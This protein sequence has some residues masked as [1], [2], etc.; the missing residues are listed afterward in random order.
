MNHEAHPPHPSPHAT[1]GVASAALPSIS[2]NGITVDNF[3]LA[4]SVLPMLSSLHHDNLTTECRELSALPQAQCPEAVFG[5]QF[6]LSWGSRGGSRGVTFSGS[7]ALRCWA[8]GMRSGYVPLKSKSGLQRDL[9][10]ASP[11]GQAAKPADYDWTF[12]SPYTCSFS[13][14]QSLAFTPLPET[15][16]DYNLLSSTD[17]RILFYREAVLYEDDLH[18]EG[19]SSLDVKVRAMPTCVFL[20][21]R[22][23]VRVD[24]VVVRNRSECGHA[25]ARAVNICMHTRCSCC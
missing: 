2:Q 11:E 17:Q 10:S 1:Q 22:M 19:C 23:F 24:E 5:S 12:T 18:D 15:G 14:P 13:S 4:T 6:R 25:E 16:V 21:L 7:D 3:T 9:S 20:R 8:T